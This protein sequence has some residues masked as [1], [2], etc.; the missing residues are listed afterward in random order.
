[1]LQAFQIDISVSSG[2]LDRYISARNVRVVEG[3]SAEVV[4]NISG[5][6]SFLQINAGIA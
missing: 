5:I 4:M 3:G 6:V 2:G 1:M